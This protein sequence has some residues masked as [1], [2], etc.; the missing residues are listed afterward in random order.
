M[1]ESMLSLQQALKTAP[2]QEQGAV[3]Y[4][5]CFYYRLSYKLW[6]ESGVKEVLM[7]LFCVFLPLIA[8]KFTLDQ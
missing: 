5:D 2:K 4:E 1:E 6:C 8:G 3:S 7:C